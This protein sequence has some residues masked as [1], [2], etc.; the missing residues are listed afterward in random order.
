MTTINFFT[1]EVINLANKE[2]SDIGSMAEKME[3]IIAKWNKNGKK[4][5]QSWKNMK[6]YDGIL[7]RD[8]S[9]C[10][11]INENLVCYEPEYTDLRANVSI[12]TRKES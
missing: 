2:I 11:W 7:C 10:N 5:I 9:D 6:V 3:N 4:L 1:E 8:D 12:S